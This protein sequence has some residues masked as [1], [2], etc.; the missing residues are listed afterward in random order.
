MMKWGIKKIGKTWSIT[1]FGEVIEG[2]FFSKQAAINAKICCMK[3]EDR[4]P[5]EDY[6]KNS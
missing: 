5:S 1:R 3:E 6:E 4:K 2:G